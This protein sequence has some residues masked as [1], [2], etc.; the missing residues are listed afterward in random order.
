MNAELIHYINKKILPQYD[1]FSDGHDR[2]HVEM[3]IRESIYLAEKY[4]ADTDMA[5]VIAAYHDLGIAHGR[6]MHHITSAMMLSDD[7][8]LLKWFSEKQIIIMKEAVEDHRASAGELP[9]SIYGCIIADADHFVEPE[10]VIRRTVQ[11]GKVNYPGLSVNEH[12]ERARAHMLEKYC[13]GG[14]LKFHLNDPRSL[15]G[16]QKLREIVADD[17]LFMALCHKS[18]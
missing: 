9:R 6:K 15:E 13:A 18:F 5:Y 1:V 14:Y 2:W 11:Y 12:I 10:D 17:V 16:L 7:E 3:V 8:N 4:A